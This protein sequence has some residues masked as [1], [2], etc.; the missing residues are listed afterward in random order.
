MPAPETWVF[1]YGS[2]VSPASMATT[3]GR[4]A[5]PHDVAPAEL[6]G[7][8]RRWNY[9][10]LSV[11]GSWKHDGRSIV[12]G[13]M[14]A[15]GL[16]PSDGERCNGVAVRVNDDDLVGLDLRERHYDRTDVTDQITLG[17]PVEGL[18][19]ARPRDARI[20]TYVPRIEAVEHYTAGRDGGRAAIRQD[21]W[22]LVD[23]AF[24]TL[25]PAHLEQYRTTPPPDI[26]IV[27]MT[28]TRR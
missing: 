6:A 17:E 16:T 22:N 18:A 26:P 25:G 14:V 1:G 10:A 24:A 15:L 12:D 9:G 13:V 21:Y 11:T 23:D 27:E 4:V 2:L 5:G 8:G 20:F 7:F 28:W 19:T 3:I